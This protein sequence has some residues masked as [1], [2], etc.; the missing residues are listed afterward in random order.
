MD[1]SEPELDMAAEG[2]EDEGRKS[3]F[4]QMFNGERT[5]EGSFATGL[6][7]L[8]LKADASNKM[9][10]AKAFPN[11]FDMEDVYYFI[12]KPTA[13]NDV[14]EGKCSECGSFAQYAESRGYGSAEALMECGDEELGNVVNGYA[15]AHNDGMN[16]G[17]MENVA[18]V[19]KIINPEILDQL[20]G[21]YGHEEYAEKLSPIVTGMN[22]YAEEDGMA[23]LNELFGGVNATNA[24]IDPA[25]IETQPPLTEDDDEEVGGL[26]DEEE[27]EGEIN[28]APPAES[29]G[30]GVVK[31]EGAGTTSVEVTKDSVNVTLTEAKAKLIKQIATGVNEYLKEW[32]FDKKKGEEHEEKAEDKE[33]DEKEEEKKEDIDEEIEA[34]AKPKIPVAAVAKVGK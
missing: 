10:L 1:T 32:N 21:D 7:G 6:Y 29:L 30:G 8:F 3:V 12:G 24:P 4:M 17:D 13:S 34:P 14:A 9:T 22:E 18:M 15:N 27:V 19:I 26:G 2:V 20:K 28:F 31:P 23:K 33:E 11:F 25:A 5:Q 16:D